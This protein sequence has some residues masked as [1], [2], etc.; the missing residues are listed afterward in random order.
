[1]ID[2]RQMNRYSCKFLERVLS[3]IKRET[4]ALK[5]RGPTGVIHNESDS[6]TEQVISGEE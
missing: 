1:M 6:R 2:D 5:G 3:A 4:R